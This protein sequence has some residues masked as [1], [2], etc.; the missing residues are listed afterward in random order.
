MLT[1]TPINKSTSSLKQIETQNQQVSYSSS[2]KG[3]TQ[4]EAPRNSLYIHRQSISFKPFLQ[5]SSAD[6]KF[7]LVVYGIN[8]NPK[9]TWRHLCSA[10][11]TTAVLSILKSFHSPVT[12]FLVCNCFRLGK[13]PEQ[14]HRPL[15]VTLSR[16]SDALSIMANRDKLSQY[17]HISTEPDLNSEDRK[18]EPILFKQRRALMTSGTNS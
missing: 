11:D 7:N 17:L 1:I 2:T 13:Y 18:V 5:H 6:Y 8:K 3:Q 10:N 12:E 14:H 16:S 4:S 9:G 15:L